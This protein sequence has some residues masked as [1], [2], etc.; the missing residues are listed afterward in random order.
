MRGLAV[1]RNAFL[2]LAALCPV[3]LFVAAGCTS[4][5][6]NPNITVYN[7]DTVADRD[8]SLPGNYGT[9][10]YR[11]LTLATMP[12][13]LIS[14]SFSDSTMKSMS[15]RMQSELAKIKRF[16]VYAVH[17]ADETELRELEDIGELKV[18]DPD[19]LATIDLLASWNVTLNAEAKHDGR[20]TT[21]TFTC[22]VN[23]TCKD[24]R[25]GVVKFSKDLDFKVYREQ[26]RNRYGHVVEGF[27]YSNKN[28]VQSFLQDIATQ[29]A[30][31][32]ANE[33]GNEYPIGG[34]ITGMLG[35]DM[36]TLD[37]G[38]EQGIDKGMQ[39]V[40][41]A[42]VGG[43]DVPLG[44]AEATPSTNTAQLDVWRLNTGNKYAARVLKQIEEDPNWL[45]HNKL[46]AVGYGMA[47][48]PEWQTKSLYLPN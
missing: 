22:T 47:M 3:A 43:V 24:L 16:S 21:I 30:I 17:G 14:N 34:R 6:I 23:L 9:E 28:N 36:M 1:K 27:D 5:G 46:Y 37:K 4:S 38:S 12:G 31:R 29:S 48:P 19:N 2:T 25:T 11:R 18:V 7:R 40:V 41:Y 32:I 44:N 13:S 33:L 20:D 35:I 8:V 15:L 26:R 45:N 39:M 42:T 10:N